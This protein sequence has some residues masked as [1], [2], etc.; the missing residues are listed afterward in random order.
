MRSHGV[1]DYPTSLPAPSG[2]GTGTG[3]GTAKA[4]PAGGNNNP[5]SYNPN[6]P[7]TKA[8]LQACQSLAPGGASVSGGPAGG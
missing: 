5:N 2:T 4:V 8:A 6:S 1:S 7:Q 3:T